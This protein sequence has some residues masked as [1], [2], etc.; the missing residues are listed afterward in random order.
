[1]ADFLDA[2][3]IQYWLESA[4]QG[5]LVETEY[6]HP[7]GEQEAA[8]VLEDPLIHEQLKR[9]RDDAGTPAAEWQGVNLN[10]LE[11]EQMEA[12]LADTVLAEFKKRLERIGIEY[13][14]PERP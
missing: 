10:A 14:T 8:L 2:Y 9:L 11:P 4:P 1:M 6:G 13:Q 5:Y 7:A 3:S 12:V